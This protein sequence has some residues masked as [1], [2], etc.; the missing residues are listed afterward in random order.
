MR[1]KLKYIQPKDRFGRTNSNSLMIPVPRHQLI[2]HDAAHDMPGRDVHLL[3]EGCDVAWN[4]DEQVA[5]LVHHPALVA[6]KSNDDEA[7]LAR[8]LAGRNDIG[9]AARGREP[10]EDVAGLAE[11]LHLPGEQRLE[12]EI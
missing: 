10:H 11:R 2:L 4:V 6:G 3:D 9:R 7:A 8:R 12:A 5:E 1:R